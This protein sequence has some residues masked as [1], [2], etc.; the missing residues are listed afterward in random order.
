REKALSLG[1]DLCGIARARHLS[2]Y[3]EV[4]RRWCDEGMNSNMKWLCRDISKRFNPSLLLP[5]ARSVIVTGLNYFTSYI[6]SEKNVPV[7]ARYALGKDYHDFITAR[8]N[9]L[10]SYIKDLDPA[11]VGR[12]FCDSSCI[13]EKA[14]DVEAGL[15]WQGKNSVLINE[16]LGS[17]LLLGIILVTTE[18]EYDRPHKTEKCGECRI[19][20]DRCPTHAI[21]DNLTI[22]ASKCISNL[23]IEN[24][25]PIDNAL[26]EIIENRIFGCDICQEVCPRNKK[27]KPHSHPEL[28]ISK[29]LRTLNLAGW[30]AMTEN[31]FRRIF[32]NSPVYRKGF[33][34]FRKNIDIITGSWRELL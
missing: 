33:E 8:L 27:A 20:I 19:C 25:E 21:N 5:G 34:R 15:G 3:E 22:D 18:L 28:K 12:V 13:A 24:R 7:V 30:Q 9:T 2:E 10:L 31:D 17:F 14:W 6:Q 23:T 29:E 11:A 32:K 16:R 1:F 4:F 26:C